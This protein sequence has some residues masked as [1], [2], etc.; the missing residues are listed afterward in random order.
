MTSAA[1][2][3]TAARPIAYFS[4]EIGLDSSMPTYSG[5]LGVLAGDSLRAAADLGIPMVAITLL[6]RKGYF[7]Q[8][9]DSI[10]LQ[11]EA[12][13]PWSPESRLQALEP[14]ISVAIEGRAVRVGAWVYRVQG[15]SGRAIPVYFLDT[16]LPENAPE[17][18]TLTDELYGGDS[19]YRLCQEVILGIGGVAMLRALGYGDVSVHHM[20]E[21]HSSLLALALLEEQV[22][23]RGL[24]SANEADVEAVRQRC[25]FTIHTPVAAGHDRFPMSLVAEVLGAERA[26]FLAH[27]SYPDKLTFNLTWMALTFSRSINAVSF[28]HGQVSRV[29][30]PQHPITAITNGVHGATWICEP[31]AALLDH[32]IP[33]WRR[34]N[35]YLR[36][37]I[38]I[39]LEEVR[40]AHGRAKG[41]LLAEVSRR[42][43]AQFD[44]GAMTI[45]FARRAT[46]Y[47]RADLLFSDV[48]RLKRIAKRVGPLQIIYAG[49]AH[50]QDDNGKALIRRIFAA[51]KTLGAT[52]PVVYLEEY[53][54]AL[55]KLL[56]AGCD[57]W[58]NT[59]QKPLEASGTSGMKAALN[60][61]P[62]L[63]VLDG[64]WVEG[65]L[66][67]VTGWSI[68]DDAEEMSNDARE[69]AS[70]YDK[71]EYVILPMYHQRHAAYTKVMRS[72]IA[73]NGA[74]FNAQRMMSQ[75]Y[76][77]IYQGPAAG[78]S[79]LPLL[80]DLSGDPP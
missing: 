22:G 75:Y 63:S 25:V 11:S 45:A 13:A 27:V 16:S 74:F 36:Q 65:H 73:L 26:G 18:R 10:G 21:G 76:L 29:M 23:T 49:K 48:E 12:P 79:A 62:S 30:F 47:K 37:A 38:G 34:D 35:R 52:V 4:M 42:T 24:A 50:P 53:D 70:L 15:V 31:I 69:A 68:G 2:D 7:R 39:P 77:S 33:S 80:A 19:R 55:A 60:G 56:L 20:N 57:L 17:D 51:A 28:R 71:L 78:K 9:L 64:W 8:R 67:G 3:T 40:S 6:H 44:P 61:V 54:I 32:H 1:L 14:R 41:E 59:P 72:A 46:A 66:E 43:G 58:L 5:G